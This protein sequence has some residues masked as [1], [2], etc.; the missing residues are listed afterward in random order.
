MSAGYQMHCLVIVT[1]TMSPVHCNWNSYFILKNILRHIT[2]NIQNVHTFIMLCHVSLTQLIL[3]Y[4]RCNAFLCDNAQ[5]THT[6]PRPETTESIL[7]KLVDYY[8]IY[9]ALLEVMLK[10]LVVGSTSTQ[11]N[12]QFLIIM[13]TFIK[14]LTFKNCPSFTSANYSFMTLTNYSTF[15]LF[16]DLKLISNLHF[17]FCSETLGRVPSL[18]QNLL[19]CPTHDNTLIL[20][21]RAGCLCNVAMS[22]LLECATEGLLAHSDKQIYT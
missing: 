17:A 6:S 14:Y 15:L 20:N 11:L 3:D 19:K 22:L 7:G 1:L 12:K 8:Y 18:L 13:S 10:A 21:N 2:I 9:Y 16:H 4:T 5:Y